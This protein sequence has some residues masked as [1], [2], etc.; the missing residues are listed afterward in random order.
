EHDQPKQ[1]APHTPVARR[2]PEAEVVEEPSE[3]A[4]KKTQF[5]KKSPESTELGK[6]SSQPTQ[7]AGSI[8][9]MSVDE[10]ETKP[11]K[12]DQEEVVAADEVAAEVLL[13]EPV[14][15]IPASGTSSIVDAI[16]LESEAKP[17]Q[18]DSSVD[19]GKREKS[20]TH[21]DSADDFFN[22]PIEPSAGASSS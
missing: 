18:N 5:G 11:K 3:T 7:L 8:P 22:I 17:K 2:A 10:A 9:D 20:D 4:S 12:H 6:K 14:E 21:P 16:E 15:A 1:R 19:F 13:D